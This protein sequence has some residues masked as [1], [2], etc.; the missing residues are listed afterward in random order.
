MRSQL[1]SV[2]QGDTLPERKVPKSHIISYH[3]ET[4]FFLVFVKFIP[5]YAN[6]KGTER[7]S[8]YCSSKA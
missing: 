6:D 3:D 5:R 7:P 1:R 4:F 8:N 2:A